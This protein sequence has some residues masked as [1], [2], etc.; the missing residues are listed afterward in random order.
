MTEKRNVNWEAVTAIATV[1]TG[2]VIAITA[3]VGVYQLR[4]LQ[5]QRRDSSAIE[6]MRALQDTTF[7]HAFR[8]VLALPSGVQAS[9]LISAGPETEEAAQ[10]LAFRFET[11]GLMV[12]RGAIPF[13][14]VEDL[15]GGG[16]VSTWGR[17]KDVVQQTREQKHWPMY[18]EWFQWLAEQFEKRGRLQ[19]IPAHI[20]L[21]GWSPTD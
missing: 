21:K 15:I 8:I 3:L 19:Q 10:I 14:V 2:C 11:L 13:D 1:F 16:V 4:Q 20:R 7:S 17:L 6:L 12:Y 5:Q 18:C 9:E